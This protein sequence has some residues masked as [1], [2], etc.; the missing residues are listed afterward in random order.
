MQH[1]PMGGMVTT[2]GVVRLLI[3]TSFLGSM[4]GFI[5]CFRILS[6]SQEINNSTRM[7]FCMASSMTL[8]FIFTMFVE[9]TTGDKLLAI[10]VP[11]ISVSI[12][13]IITMKSLDLLYIVESCATTI[14]SVSMSMMLISMAE[15][16][17]I[18]FIQATLV[19]LEILLYIS[20]SK[21]I[22]RLR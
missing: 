6:K 20:L 11:V 17:V 10:V 15:P 3:V 2:F 7:R 18:A 1:I 8:A 14:M 13:V 19:L 16:A 21:R 22:Q 4:I 9:L 12:P 5:V